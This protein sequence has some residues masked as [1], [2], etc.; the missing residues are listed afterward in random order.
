MPA[1]GRGPGTRCAQAHIKLVSPPGYASAPP[2]WRCTN[3]GQQG[4]GVADLLKAF[5]AVGK[6]HEKMDPTEFNDDGTY[7]AGI[8]QVRVARG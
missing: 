3:L 4:A 5:D 7:K 1:G 2:A 6:K 8:N